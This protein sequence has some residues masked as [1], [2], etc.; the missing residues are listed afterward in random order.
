MSEHDLKW[1]IDL[2]KRI[3]EKLAGMEQT[4]DV[5]SLRW[6][7]KQALKVEREE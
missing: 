6:L 2:V 4:E 5:V 7:A 3:E 1:I